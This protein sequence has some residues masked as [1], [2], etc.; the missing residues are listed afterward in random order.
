MAAVALIQVPA[1]CPGLVEVPGSQD[2]D[3]ILL[4]KRSEKLRGHSGQ[5]ALP[6]GKQEIGESLWQTAKRELEEETSLAGER[7]QWMGD[8]GSLITGTGYQAQVLLG[9]L[10]R[11]TPIQVDGGEAVLASRYPLDWLL[12]DDTYRHRAVGVIPGSHFSWGHPDPELD[13]ETPLWGAT[14]FMLLE[15]RR[16]LRP[17]LPEPNVEPIV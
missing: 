12:R 5:W 3:G 7:V 9:K 4:I 8:M 11:P 16:R 14:A 1:S 17:D 2:T 13:W 6:G 10:D 15:L